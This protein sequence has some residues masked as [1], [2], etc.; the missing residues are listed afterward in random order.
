MDSGILSCGRAGNNR[1]HGSIGRR[2]EYAGKI[3]G[4]DTPAKTVMITPETGAV[5][6]LKVVDT[7]EIK[8]PGNDSAAMADLKSGD[9]AEAKYENAT[10]NAIIINVEGPKPGIIRGKITALVEA[11][12][13]VTITPKQ[14]D[15]VTVTVT[16]NTTLEIWG[17]EPANFTDLKIEDPAVARFNLSTK[18]ASR[19]TVETKEED[20]K[21][22]RQGFFGTV[23]AITGTTSLTLTTKQGDILFTL[24]ATTQY[25]DPPKK[26]A[27]LSDVSV[28]DRLAVLAIKQDATLI[29]IRILIIPDKPVRQQLSG[30]VTTIDGNTVTVTT[31]DGN[32]TA[33]LPQGLAAK[34]KVG[35]VITLTMMQ[36]PG[37]DKYVASGLMSSEDLQQRISGFLDKV[38]KMK[39]DN[40]DDTAKKNQNLDKLEKMLQTNM[41]HQQ[42]MLQ[43][44]I[45]KASTQAKDALNK[46][47][48]ASQDGWENAKAAVQKARGT[49]TPSTTPNH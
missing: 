32:I 24:N 20:D 45:D 12:K 37:T 49:V 39:T 31:K 13:K 14:G 3:T 7:T 36:T 44:S 18:E 30:T 40:A 33:Q 46:A 43:K 21:S 34:V 15:A 19:I 27:T 29:A 26:N 22:P 17:K 9:Y 47:K 11:T 25:W 5:V 28:G 8:I 48:V 16:A 23:N 10:S 2:T 35:D 42:E 1:Q 4:I 38:K 41:Q 6:N